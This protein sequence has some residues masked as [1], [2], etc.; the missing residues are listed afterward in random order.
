MT[1]E[2]SVRITKITSRI[3]VS[4]THSL[5]FCFWLIFNW[6]NY[7]HI[8]KRMLAYLKIFLLY[9]KQPCM[10]QLILVISLWVVISF[11][12][13]KILLLIYAWKKDFP[14]YGTHLLCVQLALFH[15]VSYFFFLYW[16]LTSSFYSVFDYILSNI[17]EVLLINPS[18]NAFVFEDFNLHHNK[19]LTYSSGTDRT[20]ELCYNLKWP[21]SNG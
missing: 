6:I 10:A 11:S 19:W 16:A 2:F 8:I 14:L 4:W 18:V 15:S 1:V 3:A 17:D 13:K 5:T 9:E 20:S 21:Y 12:S 7:D